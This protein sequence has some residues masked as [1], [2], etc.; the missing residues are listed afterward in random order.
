MIGKTSIKKERLSVKD[1]RSMPICATMTF[2]LESG[3]AILSARNNIAYL[4]RRE[5]ARYETEADFKKHELTINRK[6]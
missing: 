3:A 2:E 6:A 5:E 4:H 1:L